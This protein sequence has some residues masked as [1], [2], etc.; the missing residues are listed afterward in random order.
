MTQREGF[1]FFCKFSVP[2]LQHIFGWCLM[3]RS[4]FNATF[5][6]AN[7]MT[8]I[9]LPQISLSNHLNRGTTPSNGPS[10]LEKAQPA[11]P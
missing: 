8:R 4:I 11:K 6:S 3:K 7:Q 1:V 10:Y 9:H 5:S 2:F